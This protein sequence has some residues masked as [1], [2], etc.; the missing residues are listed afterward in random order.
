MGAPFGASDLQL[1]RD[2][3]VDV[4]KVEVGVQS[5]RGPQLH[6]TNWRKQNKRRKGPKQFGWGLRLA[7]GVVV[8]LSPLAS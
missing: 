6:P 5:G 4:C 2:R 1:L 8:G 7:G 3:G